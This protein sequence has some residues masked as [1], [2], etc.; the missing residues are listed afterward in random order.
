MVDKDLTDIIS[1]AESQKWEVR[2]DAKGYSRFYDPDGNYVTHY[3]A[4]P[5][6]PRRRM[7]DLQVALKR[8]NLQMPPPSKSEQR[9][10]RRKDSR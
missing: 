5:S 4:T 9:A 2:T 6:N 7:K 1:W 3:P 10:Q 8:A